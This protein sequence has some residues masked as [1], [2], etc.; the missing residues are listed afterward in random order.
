[1]AGTLNSGFSNNVNIMAIRAGGNLTH[2]VTDR[3]I[4]IDD[5]G[6]KEVVTVVTTLRANGKV[7]H[8]VT[9][10][11]GVAR[12]VVKQTNEPDG[13]VNITGDEFTEGIA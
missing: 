10:P 12:S 9:K 8:T 13:G 3:A 2:M 11:A 1:M 6:D 4:D 5:D 7:K